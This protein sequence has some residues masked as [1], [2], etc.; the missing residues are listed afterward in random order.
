MIVRLYPEGI[1]LRELSNDT[2]G[3]IRSCREIKP[4]KKLVEC[5][6]ILELT[7]DISRRFPTLPPTDPMCD[8]AALLQLRNL[9][10]ELYITHRFDLPSY[11]LELYVDKV[12]KLLTVYRVPR[13][14]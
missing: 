11:N 2:V 10:R 3:L 13:E 8:E 1:L 5:H 9:T 4:V 12:V 6:D 14:R 7:L